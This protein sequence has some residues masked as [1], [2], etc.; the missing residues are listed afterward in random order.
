[1]IAN[2]YNQEGET[3]IGDRR[4]QNPGG[5]PLLDEVQQAQLLSAIATPVNESG[6][7][8]GRKVADWM[9][10]V[11]ERQVA[12][13]RGWEYLKQMEYRLRVSR[14]AHVESDPDEQEAWKKNCA[15]E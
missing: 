9:S 15:N 4:H 7:C 3:G 8:N 11:L 6:L 10:R 14:P 12:P 1:V 5:T 13:Q 2:R